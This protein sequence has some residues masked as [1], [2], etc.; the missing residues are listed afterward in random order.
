MYK[1]FKNSEGRNTKNLI[2]KWVK[3]MNNF[4]NE[5]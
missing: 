2:G 3:D 1:K 4:K 5:I